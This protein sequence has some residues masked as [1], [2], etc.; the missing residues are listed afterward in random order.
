MS[1][2]EGADESSDLSLWI[3]WESFRTENGKKI[4]KTGEMRLN[5]WVGTV[6][7]PGRVPAHQ[8]LG[9]NWQTLQL[10]PSARL[11]KFSRTFV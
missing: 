6:R 9:R 5:Y 2:V 7:Y 8:H 10:S 3:L 11:K 1:F 4:L